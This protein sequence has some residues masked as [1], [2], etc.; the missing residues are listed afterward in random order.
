LLNGTTI[1]IMSTNSFL[2]STV[3]L[4]VIG[5]L[6]QLVGVF[7][8][9][10]VARL[11]GANPEVDAYYYVLGFYFFVIL[12]FQNVLKITLMPILIDE[13]L[14][15]KESILAFNNV[16]LSYTFLFIT[17]ITLIIVF[18]SQ[19]SLLS[20]LIPQDS[21]IELYRQLFLFG[22]PILLLNI[23][24]SILSLI[25]NST[26]KFGFLEF[27]LNLRIVFAYIIL[28]IFYQKF[29]TFTLIIGNLIGQFMVV[30]VALFYLQK[31]KLINFKF[32]FKYNQVLINISKLSLLSLFAGV[33]NAAQPIISNYFLGN[34][35][36][37]GSITILS[38]LQ[39]VAS[40]PGILFTSSF[41][42][43]FLSYISRLEVESNFEKIRDGVTRSLSVISTVIL[44]VILIMFITKDE[45]M[46]ILFKNTKL[47][48]VNLEKMS[49]GLV[50]LL[51][52]FYFLQ[53][54]S[55][56]FRILVARK[57]LREILFFNFISF[58]VHFF[59]IFLFVNVLNLDVIGTVC[60]M[61][62]SN[63]FIAVF[64]F[65]YLYIKFKVFNL[66]YIS[67]NYFKTTLSLLIT[68]FLAKALYNQ[69]P[70]IIY[71][72]IL[73]GVITFSIFIFFLY[74]LFLRILRQDDLLY[75]KNILLSKVNKSASI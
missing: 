69:F 62:L 2:K 59:L 41:M 47:T 55:L 18:I 33:F 49:F 13:R 26:Q 64:S 52:S 67:K 43:V 65:A 10:E 35:S 36:P 20:Y 61:C 31:I 46:F 72:N 23:I 11:F 4:S 39:K 17:V 15:N 53:I 12:V 50:I 54:Y 38:N 42:T 3:I 24:Y 14:N 48:A 34:F 71:D 27:I 68:F 44:P 28:L 63:L 1:S 21:S 37:G 51:M 25:Y 7:F 40:I 60:A 56:L 74:V 29:G 9:I 58:I 8:M 22:S 45:V 75:I 70:I 57:L 16:L 5:I 19:T 32:D 6:F 30:V 73:F 66:S